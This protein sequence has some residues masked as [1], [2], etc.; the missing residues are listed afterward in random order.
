MKGARGDAFVRPLA[1]AA[2]G[3]Y[4][5][6]PSLPRLP[7]HQAGA[8][9]IGPITPTGEYA[10]LESPGARLLTRRGATVVLVN[11]PESA[12]LRDAVR[13]RPVLPQL[14]RLPRRRSRR[15]SRTPRFHD[16]RAAL[17]IEDFNDWHHVT[18]IGAIKLGP[19]YA[20]LLRRCVGGCAARRRIAELSDAVQLDRV[21]RSSCRSC[22]S[23]SARCRRA[24]AIRS[25]SRPATSSTA[26]WDWRFLLLLFGTTVRRLL[27]RRSRSPVRRRRR[28]AARFLLLSLGT[29]LGVLGF[30]KYCNFFVDSAAELLATGRRARVAAG[31]CGHP[32]GRHLVLHLPVD[33]L[34]H[35]RLPRRHARRRATSAT[36]RCPSRS[37]RSW[38]PARSRASAHLLPQLLAPRAA[39]GRAR[40]ASASC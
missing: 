8:R 34:H 6:R 4:R 27:G 24:G 21:P 9:A 11:N 35:R 36:T 31:R 10:E 17:P 12:L 5:V 15:A 2:R 30:F 26:A 38:S 37:S 22:C 40:A 19:S 14:P 33:G 23:A 18:Y 29:N 32:A 25:C 39:D 1:G 28:A 7:R 16:L 20:E 13:G 3:R